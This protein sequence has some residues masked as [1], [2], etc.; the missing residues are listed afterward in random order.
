MSQEIRTPM[1]AILGFAELLSISVTEP[2]AKNYIQSLK[3][4]GK[5]LLNLINDIL[6]LS[7]VDAG[8]LHLNYDFTDL[9]ILFGEIRQMFQIE[10]AEKKLNLDIDVD[11][12]LPTGIFLDEFR[13]R[14]VLINLVNNAIKF[15]DQGSVILRAR[16]DKVNPVKPAQKNF[17][18]GLIIEVE[19]T[20]IGV[21]DD[22]QK[23]IFDSFTQHEGHDTKKFGGTGLG[24]AISQKLI[25]LMGGHITLQSKLGHGSTFTITLE[26]TM[27]TTLPI[28]KEKKEMLSLG[29][30]VFEPAKILVVDDNKENLSLLAN[31]LEH[32]GLVPFTAA[33]GKEALDKIANNHPAMII[34]DIRMPQMN[35]LELLR[36]IRKSEQFRDIPV[37]CL[38]GS[39]PDDMESNSDE[40]YFDGYLSKPILLTELLTELKR[41]ISHKIIRISPKDSPKPDY[42]VQT[43][44]PKAAREV[45]LLIDTELLPLYEQIKNR[46]PVKKVEQFGNLLI[47]SGKKFRL[48]GFINY[49]NDIIE[50]L[51]SFNIEG[52]VKLI[53]LFPEII[54]PI[55]TKD[56]ET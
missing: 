37:L 7:K 41:H 52:I 24:L 47:E 3:T 26:N 56:S 1:N 17:T 32:A 29:D 13:L 5:S 18:I 25:R 22:F 42:Y 46:Q 16:P 34:T 55:K 30:I 23:I 8:M 49:G 27:A 31:I 10:L 11:P 6:D 44:D 9:K 4:S 36:F 2:S 20:G 38:S 35:G 14:Q 40:L 28:H 51:R 19:D 21:A 54:E 12:N 15:T 50:S 43:I 53:R 48:D 39:T 33:N 45:T